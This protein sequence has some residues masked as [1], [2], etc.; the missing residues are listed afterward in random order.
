MSVFPCPGPQQVKEFGAENGGAIFIGA[1]TNSI[2]NYL[3]RTRADWSKAG[4]WWSATIEQCSFIAN[5]AT[6]A[7]GAVSAADVQ[8]TVRSQMPL[9]AA[10]PPCRPIATPPRLLI[11]CRVTDWHASLLRAIQVNTTNFTANV[12]HP[13]SDYSP[14]AQ[15]GAL[16]V[17]S[18]QPQSAA[19]E[20]LGFTGGVAKASVFIQ[21]TSIVGLPLRDDY[22]EGSQTGALRVCP[23]YKV[24]MTV[25]LLATSS[26]IRACAVIAGNSSL[27]LAD[28]GGGIAI[29]ADNGLTAQLLDVELRQLTAL[30]GGALARRHGS[31]L[32]VSRQP[33]DELTGPCVSL[34][35]RARVTLCSP[36]LQAHCISAILLRGSST[37]QGCVIGTMCCL[38]CP[39]SSAH[40][41]Q[42]IHARYV[43]FLRSQALFT[44][45]NIVATNNSATYAGGFVYTRKCSVD[46]AGL[47]YG[48][49]A[50]ETPVVTGSLVD[51][52]RAVL[53]HGDRIASAP[54][55]FKV[56]AGTTGAG[57]SQ[58]RA[59]WCTHCARTL[60]GI[61]TLPR[62]HNTLSDLRARAFSFPFLAEQPCV[63]LQRAR[64]GVAVKV[65][66][67]RQ[68]RDAPRPER[69][70]G[71]SDGED[72]R[73]VRQRRP[74]LLGGKYVQSRRAPGAPD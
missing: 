27:P 22:T 45:L 20:A 38:R 24:G 72:D 13:I 17:T 28:E 54:A 52:N 33:R 8:L 49:V 31:R 5:A 57:L 44:A 51:H 56:T 53:G 60:S 3:S 47:D 43:P 71:G 12:A 25:R 21:S 70:P 1:P 58:V 23:C 18:S 35:V 6:R 7:G 55:S 37:C 40:A 42:V 64:D 69:D 46:S 61:P 10:H 32:S 73:L 4:T 15:G 74:R 26:R 41:R 39:A 67:R 66:R 63:L 11:S 2:S 34:C 59:R 16:Y 50:I 48:C 9:P 19:Y 36:T 30:R 65:P 14:N 62:R 29:V 68:A